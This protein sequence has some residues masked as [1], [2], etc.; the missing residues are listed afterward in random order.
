[1]RS[2]ARRWEN[3]RLDV[4]IGS[5][6]NLLT[7]CLCENTLVRVPKKSFEYVQSRHHGAPN[8]LQRPI[9]AI[10]ISSP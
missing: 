4:Q 10:P 1:M 3:D 9:L 6:S 8:R 5:I 2:V 7:K